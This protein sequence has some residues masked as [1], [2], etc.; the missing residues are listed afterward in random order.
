MCIVEL[1]DVHPTELIRGELDDKERSFGNYET[2]RFAWRLRLVER[3]ATPKP[4]RGRQGLWEW[5]DR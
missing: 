1:L 3:F 5:E 4:A 2:G